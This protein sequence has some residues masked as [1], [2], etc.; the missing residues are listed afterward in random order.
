MPYIGKAPKNSVRSRFTYQATAGQTSFSGSDSNA[1]TLSYVD[2]L[3]MDV[4]QNGVMLKAGTDYTATTG[5]TVVL[6]SSA[7]ADDVV[8]MVVYDVFDVADTYS[9][10]DADSRFVNVTGDSMT[11]DLTLGTT[12]ADA[13]ALLTLNKSPTAAFGNPL[14]QV[15]G[16]TYTSGGYYSIGLGYTNSTYTE[17]PA[18]IAYVPT[19][20]SG[21]TK[22]NLVFGTRNATTNTA[23][24]ER[25]RI[26][27]SGNVLVGHTDYSTAVDD[28]STGVTMG[29]DGRFTAGRDNNTV[30]YFNRENGDGDII[31]YR[32]DGSTVG[33]IGTGNSGDL[34]IGNGDT[35]LLFAGGSDAIIPT[36]QTTLRDNAIDMGHASYRFDD[37]Y[38]TNGTIQ[39]SDENEKQNIASFTTKELA[40]ATKLSALFK[41]FKWKDKVTEKADKARTHSGIV[42]QQVKTTFA[43]EGLDATNYGLFISTTWTDDNG[44]EQTR[45]GIRYPELFSFIFGSIEARLTALEAK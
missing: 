4:Y 8:E 43:S 26:D 21:G 11:G 1:L 31:E 13:S 30:A 7:S 45:M 22:G 10:S 29:A 14:L 16:S 39:T 3:Y 34:Y 12:S 17:P 6:V 37:V 25:M 42:A 2:S 40:V 38:A 19:S 35:G 5:T 36:N 41:T 20:D 18:E 9:K 24:T 27:A 44:K 32:K 15:G 28:G 23:V 33:Y